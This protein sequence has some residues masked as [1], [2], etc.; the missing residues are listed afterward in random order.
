[1]DSIKVRLPE[2]YHSR[3][4]SRL[5]KPDNPMLAPEEVDVV[6]IVNTYG[7]IENRV[8]YLQTLSAGMKPNAELLIIDFK[9][10]NLPIGPQDEYKVSLSQVEKELE[11]GGFD[12]VKID[13]ETLDFQYLVLAKK[14]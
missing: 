4:E 13:N 8:Q 7:Y 1:M 5:A 3:F 9:K 11:S 2:Q 12:L 6:I 14:R 10:N